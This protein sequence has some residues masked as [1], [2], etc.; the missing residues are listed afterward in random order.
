MSN[1]P[2]IPFPSIHFPQYDTL[3]QVTMDNQPDK[4]IQTSM[5]WLYTSTKPHFT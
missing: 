2:A 4:F 3:L 1:L 5:Y